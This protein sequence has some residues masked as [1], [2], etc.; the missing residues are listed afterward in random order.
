V[1]KTEKTGL[2]LG[3]ITGMMITQRRKEEVAARRWLPAWMNCPKRT[4]MTNN[5]IPER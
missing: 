4:K 1:K 5:S 3:D 2:A